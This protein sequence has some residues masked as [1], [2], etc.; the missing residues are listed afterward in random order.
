MNSKPVLGISGCLTGSTVRFDGG[1]KRMRFVMDELAQ[2]VTFRPVCPEMAI[3]LPVPRPALRL[4]QTACGDIRMRFSHAPQQ[5]VT[6]K[7]E[8]F[9][10]HYLPTV[11]E[12]TGFIVCAKS[13]SCGMERVRLYDEQGNR[14]SKEGTGLF[15]AALLKAY[16]WLPVEEDGRLHDPV[17]RE[18]FIERL[19]AL[20][21]LN[22]LRADGLTR[23]G[24]LAFHSRYKLQLLAHHQAG[25][26][27]IGP[28]VARLHEWN[29]LDAFFI[30]YRE[31]LMAILRQPASRKNHTNVLMHIQGYFRNQLNDRQRAELRKVIINYRAGRLPILAPLTLLKHYLAEHPD[32][33]LLTQNYFD[34]Y[35]EE[36]GLRLA[37]V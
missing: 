2:W 4:I 26:R 18:N 21:E 7:M 6:E 15:T 9:A 33:Y 31:K 29:D 1:H 20:H 22:A 19:F 25:Y 24:L 36:L 10:A 12:L 30:A 17:L 37:V 35:P 13:P 28:F 3:G 11:G 23:H 32:D 5:D 16:P 14:G 34:P 8:D 27:E